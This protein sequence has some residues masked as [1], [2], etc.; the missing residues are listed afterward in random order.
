MG[1]RQVAAVTPTPQLET[2][3]LSPAYPLTPRFAFNLNTSYVIFFVF[4]LNAFFL[5]N[6]AR[7][8]QFSLSQALLYGAGIT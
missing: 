7:N 1:E 4:L 6:I 5:L 2:G 8:T 3:L